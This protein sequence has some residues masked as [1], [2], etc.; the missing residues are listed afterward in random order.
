MEEG[1][2]GERTINLLIH[3]HGE[4]KEKVRAKD[5]NKNIH[6]PKIAAGAELPPSA[7]GMSLANRLST[8]WRTAMLESTLLDHPW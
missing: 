8:G 4:W 3:V 5:K 2:T 6:V 1:K 7:T